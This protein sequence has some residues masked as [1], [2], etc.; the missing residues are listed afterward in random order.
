MTTPPRWAE[1]EW[2]GEIAEPFRSDRQ[3]WTGL[4]AA[5]D[6]LVALAAAA[7]AGAV[8]A[9]AGL[10]SWAYLPFALPMALIVRAGVISRASSRRSRTAFADREAW[11]DAERSAVASAFLRV[12]RRPRTPRA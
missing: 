6:A 2:A 11:R 12:L 3:F 8:L 7:V 1:A 9:V 4:A 5:A 10:G